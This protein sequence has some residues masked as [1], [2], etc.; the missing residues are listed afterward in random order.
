MVGEIV[1]IVVDAEDLRFLVLIAQRRA[2]RAGK[3]RDAVR[4]LTI[5]RL[6]VGERGASR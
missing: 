4:E 3:V 1:R 5:D 6:E 2:Q